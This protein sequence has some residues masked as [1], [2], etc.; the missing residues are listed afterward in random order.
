MKK[1]T[2]SSC[3][4]L[5]ALLVMPVL[6]ISQQKTIRL[7]DKAAPGSESWNWEEKQTHKNEDKFLTIYNIVNPSLTVF[8]P[9]PAKSNGTGII[10]APG[11]GCLVLQIDNEGSYVAKW[12]V[13]KGFTVFVLKYRT[14]HINNDDPMGTLMDNY[15]KNK[16]EDLIRATIPLCAADGKGSIEYVR[17]HAAEF[18]IQP[19]RIGRWNCGCIHC[20]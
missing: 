11:G 3:S 15:N 16:W 6:G 13:E 4:L 12:L 20:I 8:T 7:Y 19:D 14:F 10:V 1:V 17:A 2:L 18:N 9:D 5:L